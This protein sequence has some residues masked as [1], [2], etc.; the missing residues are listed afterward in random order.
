MR[1]ADPLKQ[2]EKYLKKGNL[3]EAENALSA[4]TEHTAEYYYVR[5]EINFSKGWTNECK[6]D[7]EKA[8][9]LEPD[10]GKYKEVYEKITGR[11]QPEDMSEDSFENPYGRNNK[12]M[13]WKDGCAEACCEG[14]CMCCGEG[15]CQAI[16]D[17]L[18]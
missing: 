8:L 9:E 3:R 1:E 16:C 4:V 6:K 5:S 7:L 13:G 15:I 11:V 12:Q 18:G 14:S 2:A 10:N 17:G